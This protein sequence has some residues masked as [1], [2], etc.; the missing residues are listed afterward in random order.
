MS[1]GDAQ[2]RSEPELVE[3][4]EDVVVVVHVEGKNGD[5]GVTAT[6]GGAGE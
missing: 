3:V 2:R 1:W 6:A 5:I 4:H